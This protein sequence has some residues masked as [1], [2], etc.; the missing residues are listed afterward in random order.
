ML[1]VARKMWYDINIIRKGGCLTRCK[2]MAKNVRKAG[3]SV[4]QIKNTSPDMTDTINQTAELRRAQ[5]Q[6]EYPELKFTLP[7]KNESYYERLVE[8]YKK[9]RAAEYEQVCLR[10]GL[11]SY[12]MSRTYECET[13]KRS[14][15]GIYNGYKELEQRCPELYKELEQRCDSAFVALPDK[16]IMQTN[17][18]RYLQDMCNSGGSRNIFCCAVSA[19]SVAETIC[20][21]FGYD[22]KSNLMQPYEYFTGANVLYHNPSLKGYVNQNE[23]LKTLFAEGKVG[24]GSIISIS[25]TGNTVSG[26]HALTIIA[27]E[28]N[29]QG[30][31][32][33]YTV[34]GNNNCSLNV[35]NI[36][37]PF[38]DKTVQSVNT[39]QWAAD[40]IEAEV[41][42]ASVEQLEKMI[43][44]TRERMEAGIANLQ[45]IEMD[46]MQKPVPVSV[47]L[48]NGKAMQFGRQQEK[49]SQQYQ[50]MSEKLQDRMHQNDSYRLD[51]MTKSLAEN[52]LKISEDGEKIMQKPEGYVRPAA[53]EEK[54]PADKAVVRD[55]FEKMDTQKWER[56]VDDYLKSNIT[57]PNLS[58]E[59]KQQAIEA[60]QRFETTLHSLFTDNG[61]EISCKTSVRRS[62]EL[63]GEYL[64]NGDENIKSLD[65]FI[66]FINANSQTKP[67]TQK[68][69]EGIAVAPDM[70]RILTGRTSR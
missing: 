65:G 62:A 55:G 69:S 43:A 5:L 32:V 61:D 53:N 6:Y 52:E 47:V 24:P 22:G 57:A 31:V 21:K 1:D 41:Q 64:K 19:C 4:S 33:N 20:D 3:S 40:R 15:N 8:Q 68:S 37:D 30:K 63:L 11:D 38:S 17:K 2:V 54:M 25:S 67:E 44:Q 29:E 7:E 10:V 28:K 39:S 42:N 18:G 58:K 12:N 60:G 35:Y 36:N 34:Q 66:K 27:V 26:K 9:L 48:E 70:L 45:A 46:I 56:L 59:L 23:D 14:N 13:H 16:A 49:Y 51:M 50:K